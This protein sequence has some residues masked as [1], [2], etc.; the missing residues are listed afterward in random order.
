MAAVEGASI[1][2]HNP[3]IAHA[4]VT[5]WHGV[6][7]VV[8]WSNSEPPLRL[9][10]SCAVVVSLLWNNEDASDV[11]LYPLPSRQWIKRPVG[12]LGV[13]VET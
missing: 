1:P 5:R 4:G 10:D 7:E 9:S 2:H 8:S 13:R 12:V 6:Q 11:I 3:G